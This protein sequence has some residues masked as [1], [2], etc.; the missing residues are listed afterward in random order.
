MDIAIRVSEGL[1]KKG[2]EVD[3]LWPRGTKV[4]VTK[5]VSAGLKALN[6]SDG[7]SI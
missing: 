3:F 6:Q 5:V 7:N 2:H 1:I 4:N